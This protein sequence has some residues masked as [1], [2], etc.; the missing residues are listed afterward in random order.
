MGIFKQELSEIARDV[1]EEKQN[2]LFN[3]ICSKYKTFKSDYRYGT[4]NFYNLLKGITKNTPKVYYNEGGVVWLG[5]I[6]LL[7]TR[8]NADTYKTRFFVTGT[9]QREKKGKIK[10]H[11]TLLDAAIQM[12]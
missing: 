3:A 6:N 11:Q 8:E 12:V 2:K 7:G 4:D 1:V 5:N 10:G 9:K